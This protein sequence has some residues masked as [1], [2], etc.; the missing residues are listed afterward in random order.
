MILYVPAYCVHIVIKIHIEAV[1]KKKK[2][3]ECESCDQTFM[4]DP[5]NCSTSWI[6]KIYIEAVLKKKKPFECEICNLELEM[7]H[8]GKKS[9]ACC[10]CSAQKE[11]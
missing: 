8:T 10:F 4:L 3:F 5:I 1:V 9:Y 7:I 11:V 6:D 2:P